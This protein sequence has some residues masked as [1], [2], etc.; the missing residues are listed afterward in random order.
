MYLKREPDNAN[1]GDDLKTEMEF[2]NPY[3]HEELGGDAP[4][5]LDLGMGGGKLFSRTISEDCDCFGNAEAV[6]KLLAMSRYAQLMPSMPKEELYAPSIQHPRLPE[7]KT[8][9]HP[10]C[11]TTKKVESLG[12]SMPMSSAAQLA[13]TRPQT[14]TLEPR[15]GGVGNMDATTWC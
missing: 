3:I 12:S 10:P 5:S 8:S 6:N 4:Q 15:C 1:A 14:K 11:L 2:Q 9:S 7:I 13:A